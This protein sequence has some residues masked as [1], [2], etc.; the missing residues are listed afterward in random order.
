MPQTNVPSP[1]RRLASRAAFLGSLALLLGTA[2]S[3]PI[4]CNL[5]WGHSPS[6]MCL[7][8]GELSK[9]G[10]AVDNSQ[11]V[12]AVGY[13][14]M[15]GNGQQRALLV[16]RD[17]AGGL[18]SK[19]VFSTS[20]FN[21]YYAGLLIDNAGTETI[22]VGTE[23]TGSTF[24][25]NNLL[26]S[27]WTPGSGNP[28][29]APVN[30][31]SLLYTPTQLGLAGMRV[32]GCR[33]VRA[34]ATDVFVSGCT[35]REIFVARFDGTTLQLVPSWGVNGVSSVLSATP[36]GCPQHAMPGAFLLFNFY[37]QA[38]VET[39]G[40][41]VYLGGTLMNDLPGVPIDYDFVAACY[42][43]NT[44]NLVAPFNV[45]YSRWLQHDYMKAMCATSTGLY[46][47]GTVNPGSAPQMQLVCWQNDG[48]QRLPL[49]IREPTPSRG[50][51]VEVEV[52]N[53]NT[54]IYV[55]GYGGPGCGTTWHW[56]HQAIYG[57]PVTLP[58]L[59]NGAS[60]GANPKL[61]GPLQTNFDEVFDLAIGKG[62][63]AHYLFPVGRVQFSPT[64]FGQPL[65][66]IAPNGFV[67][68]SNNPSPLAPASDHG[69][70]SVYSGQNGGSVYTSGNAFDPGGSFL[71]CPAHYAAR[72]SRF[73]P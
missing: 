27:R 15:N 44:G 13:E 18:L 69:I 45:Q 7:L 46:A 73:K 39:V 30:A 24:N 59:W 66:S 58:P 10:L 22:A 4:A 43:L 38:F 33:A 26:I 70:A 36:N 67:Q 25:P 12:Y 16:V 32:W 23:F 60:S 11:R 34:S 49:F 64:T 19:S 1:R 8:H 20:N 50:N 71:L 48:T 3:A 47:T 72:M 62:L 21:S 6:P 35:D 5:M 54:E 51:D 61:Y 42:D 55:G 56:T 17:G 52:Y 37:P 31:T 63:F 65:Q 53:G 28:W 40:L 2:A 14:D 57:A 29:T 68:F 9:E 41:R